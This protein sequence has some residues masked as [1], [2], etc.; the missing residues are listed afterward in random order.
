MCLS[1]AGGG[2][3]AHEL[4]HEDCVAV[5][6]L[7]Q[8]TLAN[9]DAAET[10]RLRCRELFAWSAY[11]EGAKRLPLELP[12]STAEEGGHANGVAKAADGIAGMQLTQ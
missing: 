1:A 6:K 7:L 5:H 9:A 4:R 8:G 10:W 11:F 12:V 3:E 2:F